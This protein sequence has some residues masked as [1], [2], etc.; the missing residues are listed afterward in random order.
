MEQSDEEMAR[1]LQEQEY[2]NASEGTS[3]SNAGNSSVIIPSDNELPL[4]IDTEAPFKDIHGLFLAFN[5]LYFESKLSAC[6]VR[7]SSRMTRCAGLCYYQSRASYCSIRLSEPLLKFRS[8]SDYIDT[9]LHEMIHAYLFVTQA[10]QD[11]DGHGDDFQNHMNR[12][13]K[14]AGT[15]ISIYHTFHD[16]VEH[17]QTHIWRCNGPCQTRP[18][19]HGIVKRSMNRPPQPADKWYAKHQEECGGTYTKI[20]EPESTKKKPSSLQNKNQ[21]EPTPKARTW[22]DDYFSFSKSPKLNTSTTAFGGKKLKDTSKEKL[23]VKGSDITEKNP[24]WVQ[25]TAKGSKTLIEIN[26]D[27]EIERPSPR[28]AAA[29]AAIERQ[30]RHMKL[31]KVLTKVGSKAPLIKR[32]GSDSTRVAEVDDEKSKR[33]KAEKN[34]PIDSTFQDASNSTKVGN[35]ASTSSSFNTIEIIDLDEEIRRHNNYKATKKPDKVSIV[36]CPVCFQEKEEATINDHVD[37]C[38]WESSN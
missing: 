1:M 3:R 24:N 12:I 37:L 27:E 4:D 15:T 38:I 18:P 25:D 30:E 14:A 17:Y 34:I 19:Y 16:E 33:A 13:N 6:E 9:L 7:W 28:V 29:S 32:K 11:H 22:M 35:S 5:D 20:S 10:I 23:Q 8:E 21:E 31:N 36:Q 2:M 26:S